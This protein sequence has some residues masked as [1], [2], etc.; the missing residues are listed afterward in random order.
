MEIE[1]SELLKKYVLLP[2]S[3]RESKR[4][5]Y[6]KEYIGKAYINQNSLAKER[7]VPANIDINKV[8]D[9]YIVLTKEEKERQDAENKEE[10]A[11]TQV[12][13][14]PAETK[15]TP[16]GIEVWVG[17]IY[18]VIGNTIME[19]NYI[20]YEFGDTENTHKFIN[21]WKK[22]G[23][24]EYFTRSLILPL[25]DENGHLYNILRKLEER[26]KFFYCTYHEKIQA[27]NTSYL[28]TISNDKE[29]KNKE[30][31]DVYKKRLSEEETHAEVESIEKK[32]EDILAETILKYCNGFINEK[33]LGKDGNTLP[34]S[35]FLSYSIF[36]NK[37]KGETSLETEFPFDA[38]DYI[39]NKKKDPKFK[40]IKHVPI[41]QLDEKAGDFKYIRYN[42]TDDD[43]PCLGSAFEGYLE[44]R[45]NAFKQRGKTTI[46]TSPAFNIATIFSVVKENTGTFSKENP[47]FSKVMKFLEKHKKNPVDEDKSN[48]D[49]ASKKR[50]REDSETDIT[51]K[52]ESNKAIK[53]T[54]ET[55]NE[56][57]EDLREYDTSNQSYNEENPNIEQQ[58]RHEEQEVCS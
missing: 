34:H 58:F 40:V 47:A 56:E 45:I 18:P 26:C 3:E 43:S 24:Q 2:P 4:Q 1:H 14:K 13:Q 12:N 25:E 52:E 37:S 44:L 55:S 36:E 8:T 35:M 27:Q 10:G 9:W 7:S 11:K 41:F 46:T 29:N 23:S 39:E 49:N 20:V 5:E 42:K 57:T 22:S 17:K 16:K 30:L 32:Y 48:D 21:L 31:M 33:K 38:I 53:M 15:E 51:T 28:T 54:D 19:N 50:S 6:E